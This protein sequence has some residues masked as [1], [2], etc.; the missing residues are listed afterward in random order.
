VNNKADTALFVGWGPAQPGVP[1]QYTI[2]VVIPEAGFGGTVAAPLA[3][4]ILAPAS[5]GEVPP[6]CTTEEQAACDAA[7]EAAA[8]AALTDAV[9]VND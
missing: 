2:S 6:A 5:T 1:P 4:R 8:Q 7:A 9:G 3:F